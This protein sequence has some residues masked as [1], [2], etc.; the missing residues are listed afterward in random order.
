MD[1]RTD[2]CESSAP[3]SPKEALKTSEWTS[4]YVFGE[5]TR[6][7]PVTETVRVA[8]GIAADHGDEGEGEEHQKQDDLSK[9]E[10]KL[11]F[12]VPFDDEGVDAEVQYNANCHDGFHGYVVAPV[13]QDQVQ[14]GNL[15]GHQDRL[16]DEEV[17]NS[18]ASW[19]ARQGK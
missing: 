4:G 11:A 18:L 9:G 15:K 19:T 5:G 7:L 2:D 13:G 6:V 3:H 10:P 14:C 12:T 8:L 17:W 1:F 16:V